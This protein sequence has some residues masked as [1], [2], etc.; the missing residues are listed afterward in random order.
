MLNCV[1]FEVTKLLEPRQ[2]ASAVIVVFIHLLRSPQGLEMLQPAYSMQTG[3][4]QEHK[5]NSIVRQLAAA[6]SFLPRQS[7][8][9]IIM[10][11]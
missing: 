1:A 10:V 6:H 9:V 11:V 8:H 4:F 3:N 5:H 2:K 7:L